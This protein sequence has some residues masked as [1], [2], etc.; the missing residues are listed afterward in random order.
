MFVVIK[1]DRCRERVNIFGK[2]R[3]WVFSGFD[4]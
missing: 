1:V 3:W 4:R 2:T